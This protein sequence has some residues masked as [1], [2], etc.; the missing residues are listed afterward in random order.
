MREPAIATSAA[1][2]RT[3]SDRELLQGAWVSVTGHREA[4]LLVAGDLFA[5]HFLDGDVY[6]G[7][8]DVNPEAEPRRMDMRIDEGPLA[9]YGKVAL[10]IYDLD[11]DE[12]RWSPGKPGSSERPD[13]FPSGDDP[14][15][16]CLVFRRRRPTRRG[17]APHPEILLQ[18]E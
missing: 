1:E 12:L 2:P 15:Q 13:Q 7:T 5:I 18:E 4:Q 9:H 17:S 10:C 8:Y 14:H 16:L 6:I 11:G 3:E